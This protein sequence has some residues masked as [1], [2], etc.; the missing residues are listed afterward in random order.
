MDRTGAIL[1]VALLALMV[2]GT[3]TLVAANDTAVGDPDVDGYAPETEFVPGEEA[4]LSV[5]LNNRGDLTQSGFDNLESEVLTA[6]ETTA[7]ILTGEEAD[8]KGFEDVPLDVRTDEQAIGDVPQGT[9]GP[10][11][12]T[13]VPDKNAESGVYEIPVELEYR[14]VRLAENDN[15]ATDRRET[16]ETQVVPVVIEI[17]D[18]AEFAVVDITGDVQAGVPGTVDVTL[19]NVAEESARDASVSA[20]SVDPDLSFTS[21]AGATDTYVEEWKPDENVTFTYRVD[22]D[23]EATTRPLTFNLDVDYRDG[24]NADAEART[25]RTGITPLAE[26]SFGYEGLKST[27]RVGEDG[28]FEVEVKNEGPKNISNAVVVF[29]NEAPAVE[30]VVDEPLPTDPNVVPRDTQVTVGDLAV[31][32]SETVS[33]EAGIRDDAS[34]GDRTLN[35]ATRYRTAE[36]DL[37]VSDPADV[38][39]DVAESKDTFAVEPADP[40]TE[41]AKA[42]AGETVRYDVRVT[43][44]GPEPVTDVQAKLFVDD[45]LDA[46]DDEAFVPALDPGEE[47]TV[48]FTV[49]VDGSANSEAYAASVDF[50]YDDADGDEQLSDTYRVA[51]DVVEDDDDGLIQVMLLVVGLFGFVAAVGFTA[52]RRG[53]LANLVDDTR[54]WTRDRRE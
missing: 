50:R 8:N 49:D 3:A 32:D 27:L 2:A 53:G 37:A 20:T 43:N 48:S 5:T 39:V 15:G 14:N 28:T 11:D 51:F 35:L 30:G 6:H 4:T 34:P 41:P 44:N 31:G 7:R 54:N 9:T 45:P 26:Q 13:V 42:T 24:E 33:F 23:A 18:R 16:T 22:A 46:D 29:D 40:A 19:R 12:F 25:V 1:T 10:V 52:Y 21:N 47:T 36:G 17:T 38:V